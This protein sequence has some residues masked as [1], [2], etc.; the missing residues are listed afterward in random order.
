MARPEH[1][2]HM[3]AAHKEFADAC[4]KGGRPRGCATGGKPSH[5]KHEE[6]IDYRTAAGGGSPHKWIQGAIK[7]PGSL[8]ASLGVKEGHKIPAG[9]LAKAAHSKNPT[10]R[11]RA[12]LAKTLAGFHK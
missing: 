3:A 5:W 11:R 9:K 1:H 4:A 10:L 8:R 2:K 7:H 12:V 6:R